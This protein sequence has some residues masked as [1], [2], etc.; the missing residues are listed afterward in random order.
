MLTELNII[1]DAIRAVGMAPVASMD[2]KLPAFI[3]AKTTFEKVLTEQQLRG[4]WYNDFNIVLSP[5]TDNRITV[6]QYAGSV[7]VFGMPHVVVRGNE[8]FDLTTRSNQFDKPLR[9]RVIE[10][11]PIGSVPPRMRAFIAARTKLT[12]YVD[13]DG[14]DP[15]LTMYANADQIAEAQVVAED[16][17]YRQRSLEDQQTFVAAKWPYTKVNKVR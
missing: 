7:S 9:A 11:L 4:W 2:S 10:V 16:L 1:N 15:K 14:Q 13:E 6:P 8:L 12:H 17:R 5:G 3:N